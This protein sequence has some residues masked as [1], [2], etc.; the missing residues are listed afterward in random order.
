MF[1]SVLLF[2]ILQSQGRLLGRAVVVIQGQTVIFVLTASGRPGGLHPDLQIPSQ[3]RGEGLCT[4]SG[5]QPTRAAGCSSQDLQCSVFVGGLNY[6]PG[7]CLAL[8]DAQDFGSPAAAGVGTRQHAGMYI[9]SCFH[10]R[11]QG[12]LFFMR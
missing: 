2:V 3:S 1:C 6:P 9:V 7:C 8:R 12:F 5:D 10:C 11:Q 4:E